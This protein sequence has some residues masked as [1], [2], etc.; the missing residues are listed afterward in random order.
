MQRDAAEVVV[1]IVRLF[2]AWAYV[3]AHRASAATISCPIAN[4]EA[5]DRRASAIERVVALGATVLISTVRAIGTTVAD[6]PARDD[7]AITA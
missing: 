2:A 7:R 5:G 4:E 1:L 6:K 3:H